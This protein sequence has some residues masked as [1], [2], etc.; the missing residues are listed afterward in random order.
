MVLVWW[1]DFSLTSHQHWTFGMFI[2]TLMLPVLLYL[3]AGLILP[4]SEAH[5][6]DHMRASYEENRVWFFALMSSAVLLSFAQTYLIDGYVKANIDSG[7][8]ILIALV[9][10]VPIFTRSDIAQKSVALFN[11]AWLVLYVSLLFSNLP[12]A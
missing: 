9:S 3:C 7:L 1:A 6:A 10:M 2:V 4:S 8:K 11:L 5:S 12:S